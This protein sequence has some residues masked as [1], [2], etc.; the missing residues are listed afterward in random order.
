M[1]LPI[2]FNTR[3]VAE[4]DVVS[5]GTRLTPL[6][7][8]VICAAPFAAFAWSRPVAVDVHD[9]TGG[10]R[11][12]L[13]NSR[14]EKGPMIE[15]LNGVTTTSTKPP[16]ISDETIEKLT[17]FARPYGVYSTPVVSGAYTVIT[18]SEVFG[19]GGFGFGSAP[20][21]GEQPATAGA[22]E[23]GGGGGGGGF[24]ARPVASIVIGPD[25]VKIQPI[26]DATKIVIA[27]MSAWVGVAVMAVRIARASR[28]RNRKL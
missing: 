18:A 11:L 6:T 1:D 4:A 24:Y 19:G 16:E 8:T 5:N 26:A 7:R 3:L 23:A 13:R 17:A 20:S 22:G 10:R 15:T 28:S 2:H 27:V 14:E 21:S 9:A 25:G 12:N